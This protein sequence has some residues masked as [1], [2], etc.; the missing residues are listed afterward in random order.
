MLL[1]QSPEGATGYTCRQ[2][3]RAHAVTS[4]PTAIILIIII[5]VMMTVIP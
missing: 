2:T 1:E 4:S 5:V 3:I